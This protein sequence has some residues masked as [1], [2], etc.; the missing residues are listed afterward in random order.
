MYLNHQKERRLGGEVEGECN[1]PQV[2][3]RDEVISSSSEI[4][5]ASGRKSHDESILPNEPN[6]QIVERLAGENF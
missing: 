5:S 2:T 1:S 6:G 4:S 3:Q